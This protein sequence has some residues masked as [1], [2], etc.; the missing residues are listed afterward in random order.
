MIADLLLGKHWDWLFL[1]S[2]T[3]QLRA[4]PMHPHQDIV[5]VHGGVYW[6]L[7]VIFQSF[8]HLRALYK[9]AWEKLVATY[10]SSAG[11]TIYVESHS[12]SPSWCPSSVFTIWADQFEPYTIPTN[13]LRLTTL[14]LLAL[15]RQHPC[16][17]NLIHQAQSDNFMSYIEFQ[18]TY[19][20]AMMA[21]W[22]WDCDEL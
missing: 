5:G 15:V 20:L 1:K 18:G 4:Q 14:P 3:K 11:I 16:F 7:C 19:T 6:S 21:C 13:H 17:K 10:P 9:V 12:D 22:S 8:F 2:L